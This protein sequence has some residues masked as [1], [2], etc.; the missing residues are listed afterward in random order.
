MFMYFRE[1][2]YATKDEGR[3]RYE[4]IYIMMLEL[5]GVLIPMIL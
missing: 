5:K 1:G 4:E 3:E 2:R